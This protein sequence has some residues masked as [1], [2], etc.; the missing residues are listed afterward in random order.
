[1]QVDVGGSD[2]GEIDEVRGVRF[3]DDQEQGGLDYAAL[4]DPAAGEEPPVDCSVDPCSLAP[5]CTSECQDVLCSDG[6]NSCIDNPVICDGE[7]VVTGAVCDGEGGATEIAC[8]DTFDNNLNGDVDCDDAA[9]ADLEVCDTSGTGGGGSSGCSV[10][11]ATTGLGSM[12]NALV[13]LIP[14]FGIGVRR[15]RRRLSK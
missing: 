14:A 15:I 7:E 3:E 6:L 5:D 12:A 8:N 10:A 9:C 2:T 4:V 13:L 11:A 1:M